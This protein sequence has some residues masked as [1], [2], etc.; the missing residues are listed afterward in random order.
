MKNKQ[1]SIFKR[2]SAIIKVLSIGFIILLLLIPQG[3]I[4]GLIRERSNRQIKA[5][6]EVGQKWGVAQKLMGP[7]LLIPYRY[8]LEEGQEIKASIKQA[9]FLPS[10]LKIN[11]TLLPDIRKRGIYK[12][13][14]YTYKGEIS[15][16]FSR[17]DFSEWEIKEEDILYNQAK[18]VVGITDLSGINEEIAIKWNEQ[19]IK[20]K[21]GVPANSI[22]ISG[23][24]AYIPI[25]SNQ[26]N[27]SIQLSLNGSNQISFAPMGEKTEAE[28]Q[29]SWVSPSF[30][31]R[32]IPDKR[33][34]SDKGFSAYW[35]ILNLNR[36]YP[37]KWTSNNQY[38]PRKE[39]FSVSLFQSIDHYTLN[40][41]TVK[42]AIIIILLVFTT[43]FFFEVLKK[44]I[45]HP[46]QYI[47]IGLAISIFYLLLLSFSEHIGFNKAYL[48]AATAVISLILVY[49]NAI[50]KTQKR[51]IFLGL[52][53]SAV[54]AFIYIILQ[55]EDFA[56]LAGSIGLFLAL[57][58]VMYISRKV[59]W[60][61][62]NE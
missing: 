1:A 48:I 8:Y 62:L 59:N 39:L 54:F 22:T 38:Q 9:Y 29:S 15:G 5:K 25:D 45:I 61:Q 44:E 51:V 27:F 19:P 56:L 34:I 42:Y 13:P 10:S 20:L 24:H 31:G 40:T 16:Q 17:P 43:F 41:R 7:F 30:D 33:E 6:S 60:Y 12:I 47:F 14:V 57:A 53:L 28:L 21:P 37:Q 4:S 36:N 32:F 23:I 3:M 35:K 46:L 18:V 2:N 58:T 49:S 52:A 11:G 55:M 26:M 50:L